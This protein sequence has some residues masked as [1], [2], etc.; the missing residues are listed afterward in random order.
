M[1]PRDLEALFGQTI[2]QSAISRR[3]GCGASRKHASLAN[4]RMAGSMGMQAGWQARRALLVSVSASVSRRPEFAQPHDT[5]GCCGWLTVAGSSRHD[6]AVSWPGALQSPTGDEASK[7][8]TSRSGR[9][10]AGMLPFSAHVGATSSSTLAGP[11]PQWRMRR[12]CHSG[13]FAGAHNLARMTMKAQ[14]RT[15]HHLTNCPTIPPPSHQ[16]EPRRN[17]PHSLRRGEGWSC[18]AVRCLSARRPSSRHR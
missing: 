7:P 1:D 18:S 11:E 15:K 4:K 14:K 13:L 2:A 9:E 17:F 6:G 12:L 3:T 16:E 10:G 8:A 5:L